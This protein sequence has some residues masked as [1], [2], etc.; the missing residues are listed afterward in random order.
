MGAKS[1]KPI[2]ISYPRARAFTDPQNP[3]DFTKG[4]HAWAI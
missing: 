4:L 1:A 2:M 3:A